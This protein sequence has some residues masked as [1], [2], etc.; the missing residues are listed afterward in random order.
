MWTP[1][2]L[3][4]NPR[5][6]RHNFNQV[7]TVTGR[8]ASQNPNLQNIPTRTEIGRRVRQGFIAPEGSRLLAVDYS[9]VELRI[10]AHIAQDKAMMDAFHK[11]Q[12]IHATTAAAIFDLPLEQVS[13]CPAPACQSD[14][15]WPDLRHEPFGLT[16]TTDLTLAEAENFV[17]EY[18]KEFPA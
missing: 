16:R 4:V 12:D 11:G 15:L 7:G 18:F 2:S 3:Q 9:Q 10:M 1:C 6:G 13:K 17:A 14:Q 8:I 5:D